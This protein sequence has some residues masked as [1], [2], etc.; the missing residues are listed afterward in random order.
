V[1]AAV[2]L[3]YDGRQRRAEL[4]HSRR[5]VDRGSCRRR[6]RRRAGAGRAPLAGSAAA[7]RWGSGQERLRQVTDN[8]RPHDCCLASRWSRPMTTTPTW[9]RRRPR[10]SSRAGGA[11]HERARRRAT[12][13]GVVGARAAEGEHATGERRSLTPGSGASTDA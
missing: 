13:L 3:H 6:D 5:L 1:H 9:P 11:E 2:H 12:G 8:S 7:E 4:E 10:A